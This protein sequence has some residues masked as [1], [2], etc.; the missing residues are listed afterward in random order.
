METTQVLYT[1]IF[2]DLGPLQ[3]AHILQYALTSD[4]RETLPYGI[5]V[6]AL[7]KKG[8]T[9]QSCQSLFRREEDA[10]RL[11]IFLWEN[12]IEPQV[13]PGLVEDLRRAGVLLC[14]KEEK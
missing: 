4:P 12:A 9:F 6:T 1:R 7:H 11:L 14:Q 13:M 5:V 10:C 3:E 2:T 8:K